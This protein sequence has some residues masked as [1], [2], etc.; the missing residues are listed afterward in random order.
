MIWYDWEWVQWA[1]AE[2]HYLESKPEG[3]L[4]RRVRWRLLV[5][6]ARAYLRVGKA[7]EEDS[8]IRDA[9]KLAHLWVEENFQG[10]GIWIGTAQ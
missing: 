7:Q 6:A 5:R 4:A 8:T 9:L 3:K 10:V 2:W 1:R